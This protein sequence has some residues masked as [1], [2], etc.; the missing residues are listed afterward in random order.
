MRTPYK[1]E[2]CE[3]EP[4]S[5]TF[6][7]LL[8]LMFMCSLYKPIRTLLMEG[9]YTGRDTSRTMVYEQ[10]SDTFIEKT[11]KLQIYNVDKFNSSFLSIS[12]ICELY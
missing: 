1:D 9:H 2:S 5:L 4:K 8:I 3:Q 7:R 12:Q 6:C 10:L 11:R